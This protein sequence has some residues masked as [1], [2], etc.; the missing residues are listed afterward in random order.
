M[1]D[2]RSYSRVRRHG[3][4]GFTAGILGRDH[5]GALVP[6]G[7][8]AEFEHALRLLDELLDREGS[9]RADVLR[10]GVYL[11]D[12]GD[13]VAMDGVFRRWFADPRPTRTT[14]EVA[15]LPGSASIEI[16]ASFAVRDQ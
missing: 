1:S 16:E 10:L 8:T 6:G 2:H 3:G 12:I 11:T 4:V 7:T 13:L 15:A 5:D 14:I 9:S